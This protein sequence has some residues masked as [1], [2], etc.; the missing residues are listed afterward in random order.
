MK[1]D[2]VVPPETIPAEFTSEE[3][4][5]CHYP[6]DGRWTVSWINAMGCEKTSEIVVANN[7]FQQ[8]GW[9][10][11]LNFSDPQH[12][13]ALWP[14]SHHRQWV[15]EG[16]DLTTEPMGPKP[17]SKIRWTTSDPRF[18][19]LFWVRQTVGPLPTPKVILFGMGHEKFLYQR[20][21]AKT[22]GSIPKYN[23]NSVFGNVF[24]KR[25]YIGSSSYHFL[26]PT[27]CFISYR[28]PACRDL[29]PLDDGSPLPT[30][31]DF[32][33]VVWDQEERHLTATIEWEKDFGTSWNDNVRWTLD[34]YFD[35]EYMVI[36]KGDIQCEWCRERRARPRPPRPPPRHRPTPVAVYVPPTPEEQQ[37]RP[38]EDPNRNEEWVMSGY[39]HDQVYINAAALE[40]Y[41]KPSSSC[42][43]GGEVSDENPAGEGNDED[44]SSIIAS[45]PLDYKAI[46][47]THFRRLK[48]E[49]A[50]KRSIDFLMHLFQAAAEDDTANPIDFLMGN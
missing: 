41:R 33:N 20:L 12:P 43:D 21:H 29:P 23:G 42:S 27:N 44:C 39:G 17:G 13:F 50:T 22:D 24:T 28:H 15:E 35:T 38:E 8:S 40:R 26:S 32:H 34:M 4:T 9:S 18:P 11:Y 5:M 37:E 6:M 19:E 36:L 48:R 16:V 46:G 1:R 30:R 49:G 45:E 14:R 47:N 31:V 7:E 3:R 25:L 2:R 10:F